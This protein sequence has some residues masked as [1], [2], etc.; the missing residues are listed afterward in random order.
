MQQ[1]F[2]FIFLTFIYSSTCF[3]LPHAHHQ[4]INNCSSSV[5]FY[6]CIVVIAVLLFVVG[7][8]IG[9]LFELYDDARTYKLQIYKR[10]FNLDS[11]QSSI[12]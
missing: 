12:Y 9:D 8:V 2:Q 6:L 10:L 7:P 1:F 4:E 11:S 3:G 5:W